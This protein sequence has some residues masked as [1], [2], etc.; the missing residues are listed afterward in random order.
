MNATNDLVVNIDGMNISVK[1]H[2]K[3]RICIGIPITGSVSP[4]F[5]R[6]ML[7][8][9][10]EWSQ[11]F[12]IVPV[13]E[14][15]IPHDEGRNRIARS[16][17]DYKC[18][19]IFFIDSD[20]LIQKGQLE[21]LLS[22][23]K[24]AITGISYMKALPYY[25]LIRKRIGYRLY[26]PIEP[27]G[28]ELISIDGAGFGCFLIKT[29]VFNK[30]EYP[31]F[32]FKYMK[33]EDRWRHIGEDLYFC[34]QLE[35]AKIE[36][37]CDPTVQ[38][39]HIGT[40]LTIDIANRYKDLRLSILSEV[41][42]SKKELSEFTGMSLEQISDRCYISTDLVAEQYKQNIIELNED[43]KKFYKENK[44]YIFDLINWHMQQRMIFDMELIKDIKNK[45]PNAKKILDYGSGCGQ[46][47]I[48]L[49][50]AAKNS[51]ILSYDVAMV[52]YEGY[53][54]DFAKFRAK[55][56]GLNIKYYDIEKPIN[57]KFDI[58]LVFDILEHV[59]D[60][61]FKDTINRLKNLKQN[62]CKILTTVS[63]GNQ[64]GAHPMHYESS[65]E[66]IE[67]IKQLVDEQINDQTD[68]TNY[69]HIEY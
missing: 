33:H 43:P 12:D 67:L 35:N 25:S 49:A 55:K 1:G 41:E 7:L 28:T 24:D 31:W 3:V 46:N 59:P 10:E 39:I 68:Q 21:Q 54:F 13:I 2:R 40:H 66:K 23:D 29:D 27:S 18:D 62:G 45:Y 61:Q 58:I 52:D 9:M 38:C 5:F 48:M 65:P 6:E 60:Y 14:T 4:E 15:A 53:T 37:Y 69:Q 30:I 11:T 17:I 50:E 51:N 44:D 47:A 34:D 56:R 36:I 64:N 42:R 20:T 19:Y 32:Q 8:R 22:H 63:F 57:D 26:N 16:A